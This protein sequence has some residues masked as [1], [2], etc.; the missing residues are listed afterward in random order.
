MLMEKRRFDPVLTLTLL[1]QSEWTSE[2]GTLISRPC[3][4]L[5]K[6][7]QVFPD[8]QATDEVA[9]ANAS[10]SADTR[11]LQQACG[12]ISLSGLLRW[13]RMKYR[14]TPGRRWSPLARNTKTK[15]REFPFTQKPLSLCCRVC[16]EQRKR[17]ACWRQLA[18]LQYLC[19]Q[20]FVSSVRV[21]LL[22]SP[23]CVCIKKA[24][25]FSSSGGWNSLS[26]PPI[27]L[28]FNFSLG[29]PELHKSPNW[30]LRDY[31][32]WAE[33][34]NGSFSTTIISACYSVFGVLKKESRCSWLGAMGCKSPCH[35][36]LT[37]GH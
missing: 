26:S 1:I 21:T 34:S 24:P 32:K 22:T 7:A 8:K 19:A 31:E 12:R 28:H 18:S 36:R 16:R 4:H 9:D 23:H 10:C 2:G 3:F 14:G 17:L 30:L 29:L 15:K 13:D 37:A 27:A 6:R 20:T 5:L 25:C 35:R 11:G 33:L